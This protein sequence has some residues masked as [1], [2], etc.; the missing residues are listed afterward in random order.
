MSLLMTRRGLLA[1][2][3]LL[4]VVRALDLVKMTVKS[5]GRTYVW[6]EPRAVSNERF[7]RFRARLGH[8]RN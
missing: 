2:F 5:D 6:W 7:R 8:N 3:F 1:S 4:P